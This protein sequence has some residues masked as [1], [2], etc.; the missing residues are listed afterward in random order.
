M[1]ASGPEILCCCGR[2]DVAN[3]LFH[4]VKLT[5]QNVCVA[6]CLI[7]LPRADAGCVAPGC[8]GLLIF[9][10]GGDNMVYVTV[11]IL[12]S[13]KVCEPFTVKGFRIEIVAGGTDEDLRISG[14]TETFIALRAVGRNIDKVAFLSPD[15]V[16]EQFI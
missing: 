11:R 6:E 10:D 9:Q 15:D 14:P 3:P 4:A 13:G 1:F 16:V 8:A 5:A 7:K 2:G 12:V